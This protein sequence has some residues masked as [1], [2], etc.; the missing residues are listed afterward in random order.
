[1]VVIKR[2]KM[3][4]WDTKAFRVYQV[5]TIMSCIPARDQTRFGFEFSDNQYT[6]RNGTN[7]IIY[8]VDM[9]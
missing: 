2:Q 5:Y 3:H 6:N 8:N 1:M 4:G 9:L 7:C